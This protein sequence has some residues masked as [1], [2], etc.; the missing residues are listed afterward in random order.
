M[1]G[2]K[3]VLRITLSES[4]SLLQLSSSSYHGPWQ[5][6]ALTWTPQSGKCENYKDYWL[7]IMAYQH[8]PDKEEG[9]ASK[10]KKNRDVVNN[11]INLVVFKER[12]EHDPLVENHLHLLL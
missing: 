2:N 9:I 1:P 4:I 6:S 10:E 3:N 5:S 7:Q 8:D 11:E 12:T